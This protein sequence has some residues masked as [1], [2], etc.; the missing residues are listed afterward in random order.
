[1]YR[2]K[3][4]LEAELVKSMPQQMAGALA[5]ESARALGSLGSHA[6]GPSANAPEKFESPSPPGSPVPPHLRI[7]PPGRG[8][9]GRT[10]GHSPVIRRATAEA[11]EPTKRTRRI[12][13]R[14]SWRRN[15]AHPQ[16][17]PSGVLGPSARPGLK[18]PPRSR[19]C[20]G[21]DVGKL[22]ESGYHSEKPRPPKLTL[23]GSRPPN[24]DLPQR[25]S[26]L[27]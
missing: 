15:G 6:L 2:S 25:P 3:W 21:Y 4:R 8:S 16:S 22:G 23:K 26:L 1:M 7:P 13:Q 24:R 27:T 14:E 12:N 20:A 19:P 10:A 18:P 17:G 11:E 9:R 5:Q